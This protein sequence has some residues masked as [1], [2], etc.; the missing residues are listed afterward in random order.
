[1]NDRMHTLPAKNGSQTVLEAHR[2]IVD[3]PQLALDF[4]AT[5]D[6]AGH[7]WRAF[8]L[9]TAAEEAAAVFLLRYG[10]HPEFVFESRGLLLAG[11]I[12]AEVTP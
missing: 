8:T 4:Y 11:P 2:A 12:P 10:T 9:D 1:M 7:T 3:N 6:P 5:P